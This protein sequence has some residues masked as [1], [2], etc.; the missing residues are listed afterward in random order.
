[1]TA[2]T[3]KRARDQNEWRS[4]QEKEEQDNERKR[5]AELARIGNVA[6]QPF[7]STLIVE[8]ELMLA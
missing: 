8:D 4:E 5:Q 6:V 1:M 2:T 3:S 7:R